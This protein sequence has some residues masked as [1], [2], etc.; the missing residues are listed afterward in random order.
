[1]LCRSSSRVFG[2]YTRKHFRRRMIKMMRQTAEYTATGTKVVP[3]DD[4]DAELLPD[5]VTWLNVPPVEPLR[6][7]PTRGSL[8]S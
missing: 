2:E 5:D 6:A 4:A 7:L 3:K 1:V 8:E